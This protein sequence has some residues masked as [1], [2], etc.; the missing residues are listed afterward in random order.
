MGIN[1]LFV[2]KNVSQ[3]LFEGYDDPLLNIPM[4]PGL[5]ITI[6]PFDKFGWF[7]MVSRRSSFNISFV[8]M[9]R[10]VFYLKTEIF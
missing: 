10:V 8:L 6:P 7:Y 3:L 5:N 9:T 4:P 2:T 1:S